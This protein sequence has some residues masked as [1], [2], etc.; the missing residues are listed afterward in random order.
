MTAAARIAAYKARARYARR[1]DRGAVLGFLARQGFHVWP[2]G[3][4]A[5]MALPR[6]AKEWDTFVALDRAARGLVRLGVYS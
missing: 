3:L 1:V 6:P 4:P 5:T 2:N